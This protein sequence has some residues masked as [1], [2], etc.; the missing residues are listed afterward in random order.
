MKYFTAKRTLVYYD[1]PQLLL[2][3][4]GHEVSYVAV[5][6]PNAIEHQERFL[7]V[8]ATDT[9][10]EDYLFEAIDLRSL[11]RRPK[12]DRYYILSLQECIN[13][14]YPLREIQAI[15]DS[16]LPEAGFFAWQH[17]EIV[18]DLDKHGMEI[19][20]IPIDGRWDMQ[21][22]SQFPN[23]YTDA[24][25]FLYAINHR[26]ASSEELFER[27]PWRGG[28][29]TVSFY[30][31]LYKLI[32]RNQKL[33]IKEIQYASP[34]VIRINVSKV[35][36]G[37]LRTL[38]VSMNSNWKAIKEVAK[39]LQDGM[40]ERGYLGVSNYDIE[41]TE[42][43]TSFLKSCCRKLFKEMQLDLAENI[44]L[45]TGKNWI[46]TAKILLSFYRRML[47]L[48]NFYDSGKAA[49]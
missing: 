18:S 32:P 10:V 35:I 9:R 33:R 29:S 39:E 17:T 3:E 42:I 44:Y 34:G 26:D 7:A 13:G 11:F 46:A 1:G 23:K 37:Q 27:Y 5:A 14:R 41:K 16:W 4:D 36:S 40:S 45:L 38:V 15:E 49:M 20:D 22:L 31:D 28:L 2:G 48:S 43:D 21:D 47:D 12:G 24:Y 30:N 8:A 6:I 19:L 25:A